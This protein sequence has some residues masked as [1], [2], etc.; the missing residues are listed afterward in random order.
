V[1]NIYSNR[2]V[3]PPHKLNS[4]VSSSPAVPQYRLRKH[5]D[6]L[7]NTSRVRAKQYEQQRREE[8]RLREVSA[9]HNSP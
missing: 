8:Q 5:S 7:L 1:R 3:K 6:P 2:I 4:S 9:R